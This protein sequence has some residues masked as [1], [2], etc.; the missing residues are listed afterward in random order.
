MIPQLVH[1]YMKATGW[2]FEG[3]LPDDLRSFVFLGVPHTSNHDVV[4]ALVI[5]N[6]IKRN[7]K[8]VIKSEWMKPPFGWIL[9]AGGAIGLDRSKLKE[10]NRESTIDIMA[11]LFKQYDELVLL[12]AP[13]GTRKPVDKWKT[14][15]YYIAQK[16]GVPIV[17]GFG[18]YEKKS[19]GIGPIIHL[20]N[21]EDDMA[22]IMDFYKDIKGKNPQNFKLHQIS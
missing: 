14:G 1:M 16:A 19:F 3:T 8:F 7:C 17:C 2:K 15:F 18:D 9:K 4:P 12:I 10:G 6:L 20:T 11:R 22:K 5:G 21:F 13:E